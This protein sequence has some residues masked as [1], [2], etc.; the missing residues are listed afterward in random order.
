[1]FDA[2]S[3]VPFVDAGSPY[4]QL[5]L[6]PVGTVPETEITNSWLY[7]PPGVTAIS[8]QGYFIFSFNDETA[9]KPEYPTGSCAVA[10]GPPPGY[11]SNLTVNG[12]DGGAAWGG[13][14]SSTRGE[15]TVAWQDSV[16]AL[17][18]G[19]TLLGDLITIDDG[20][21]NQLYPSSG[22]EPQLVTS[23]SI[24]DSTV[25]I[26]S[27]D[28]LGKKTCSLNVTS[29]YE[30]ARKPRSIPYEGGTTVLTFQRSAGAAPGG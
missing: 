29:L 9:G 24:K 13:L 22:A 18:A 27:C 30:D 25:P 17:P 6:T 11:P 4:G 10:Y 21:G 7:A 23:L 14:A 5:T 26:G 2:G 28:A 15:D 1:M 3:P 8:N 12:M 20:S 16:N 19:V